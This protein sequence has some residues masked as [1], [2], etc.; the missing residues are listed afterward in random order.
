M[1]SGLHNST[2]A[3]QLATA[4]GI[5]SLVLIVK[6][7]TVVHVQRF[8]YSS[9]FVAALQITSQLLFLS[10]YASPLDV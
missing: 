3:L 2:D 6:I 1:F 9:S 5:D 7:K 10:H 8:F 4:V